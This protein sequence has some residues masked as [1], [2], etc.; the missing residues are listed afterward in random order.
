MGIHLLQF[1]FRSTRWIPSSVSLD[2]FGRSN[3]TNKGLQFLIATFEDNL[4]VKVPLY[5]WCKLDEIPDVKWYLRRHVDITLGCLILRKSHNIFICGGKA[6]KCMVG[7]RGIFCVCWSMRFCKSSRNGY[8]WS[9]YVVGS[10]WQFEINCSGM[11]P[12]WW[13]SVR[14][15]LFAMCYYLVHYVCSKYCHHHNHEILEPWRH[16]CCY[17]IDIKSK[18]WCWH[19][20]RFAQK[21]VE[22]HDRYNLGDSSYCQCQIKF[23]PKGGK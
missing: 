6:N 18:Y 1:I 16:S 2:R 10:I 5:N 8:N 4:L 3:M 15:T 11:R 14:R 13:M 7:I 12:C 9:Q 19:I 21:F 23:G 17:C 20:Y 22:I